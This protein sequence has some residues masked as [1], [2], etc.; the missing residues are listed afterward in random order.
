MKFSLASKLVYANILALAAVKA[1]PG[2]GGADP[3]DNVGPFA[4]G[5]GALRAMMGSMPMGGG[6][7]PGGGGGSGGPGRSGG[8]GGRRRKKTI[9]NILFHGDFLKWLSKKPNFDKYMIDE[10]GYDPRIKEDKIVS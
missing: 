9:P 10:F 6:G 7:G 8:G 4:Q 5:L 1:Q 3:C 2:A